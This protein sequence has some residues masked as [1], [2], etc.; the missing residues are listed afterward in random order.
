M[1]LPN[2]KIF[3]SFRL[4]C[5]ALAGLVLALK[6]DLMPLVDINSSLSFENWTILYLEAVLFSTCKNRVYELSAMQ[7]DALSASRN[8]PAELKLKLVFD[9]ESK[10]RGFAIRRLQI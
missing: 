9:P 5:P 10:I 1:S 3:Y 6:P 7:C 8:E 2:S 4:A